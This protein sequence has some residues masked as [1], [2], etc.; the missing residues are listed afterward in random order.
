M[1][2][3]QTLMELALGGLTFA[4]WKFKVL[5]M[6][7]GII[8]RVLLKV[9]N[10]NDQVGQV[11]IVFWVRQFKNWAKLFTS[12]ILMYV[13]IRFYSDYEQLV[14]ELIPQ[15]LKASIYL[16]M[17]GIGFFLHKIVDKINGKISKKK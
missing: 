4:K 16:I 15:N 11:S 7:L 6:T 10:R 17:F 13:L 9:S 1:S 14:M 2:E 3:E 8:L 12:I 5:L